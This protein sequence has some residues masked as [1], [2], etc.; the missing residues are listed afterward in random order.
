MK[1]KGK[2]QVEEEY[3]KNSPFLT[4]LLPTYF[5]KNMNSDARI[6]DKWEVV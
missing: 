3:F 5:Y 4:L 2:L 1:S 6:Q